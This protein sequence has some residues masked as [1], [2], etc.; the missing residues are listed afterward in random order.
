MMLGLL[1]VVLAAVGWRYLAS[2]GP[3]PAPPAAAVGP[4]SPAP[5]PI[6]QVM[7]PAPVSLDKLEGV[8]EVPEN[9]RNL[10]RFGERPAPPPPPRPAPV[11]TPPPPAPPP[12]PVGPPPINLKLIGITNGGDGRAVAVLKDPRTGAT[13]MG[14]DGMI[15]DGQYK[16][17]RVAITSVEISYADGSGKRTIPLGS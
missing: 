7:L 17:I 9:G 5:A 4:Q 14:S 3:A 11:V 2:A 6:A 12:Q 16:I 10:F 15:V 1:L 8:P 13:F